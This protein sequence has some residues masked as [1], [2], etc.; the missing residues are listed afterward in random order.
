MVDAY[1]N[2]YMNQWMYIIKGLEAFLP[3]RM[4]LLKIKKE[5]EGKT[6]NKTKGGSF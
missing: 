4:F 6:I 2:Q 5:K 1:N 3:K